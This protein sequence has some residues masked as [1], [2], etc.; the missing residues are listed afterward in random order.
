M[1]LAYIPEDS[2]RRAGGALLLVLGFIMLGSW[3]VLQF[4]GRVK[5]EMAVRGGGDEA[6]VARNLAFQALEITIGVLAEI[7]LLD[8]GLYN[9]AQ[10]WGDPLAFAGLAA[11][12]EEDIPTGEEPAAYGEGLDESAAILFPDGFE[13]EVRIR[14]ESGLLPLNH[15]SEDRWKHFF[16]LMEFS[17]DDALVLT[18]SLL[19]WI[20]RDD[21][22][23]LHG[24]EAETYMLRSPPYRPA[25]APIT[26]LQDLLLI[27]GFD[28]LFFDESGV[29]N[30]LFRTFADHV[31]VWSEGSVNMNTAPM[32]V[33]QTLAEDL[34]FEVDRVVDFLRGSDGDRGTI[35]DRI[36]RP[37][38]VEADVPRDNRGNL[39][40]FRA[41]SRYLEVDVR[42]FYGTIT[43]R[44]M[45]RLDSTES[46]PE[47]IYPMK[48]VDIQTWGGKS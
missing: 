23:R 33:L 1:K 20:D 37:G 46:D 36:L 6:F 8:G 9:P 25:N 22:P 47:D 17:A 45:A 44:L 28:R 42:V 35:H 13:V 32:L 19:D 5:S 48:I 40:D 21:R 2:G 3:I 16:E 27:Q 18:H 30:E 14:D 38:L 34:N 12:G 7:R 4:M 31:S 41:E 43:F 29:P 10:G 26:D 11:R 39:L 24:A 15:T